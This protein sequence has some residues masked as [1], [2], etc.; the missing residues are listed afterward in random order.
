MNP[1]PPLTPPYRKASTPQ[2]AD[3]ALAHLPGR[4]CRLRRP[5]QL[6]AAA[7][8][9]DAMRAELESAAASLPSNLA[10]P[11]GCS[12]VL[13]VAVE[14]TN[15]AMAAWRSRLGTGLAPSWLN[16]PWLLVEC[17]MYVRIQAAIQAQP[18]LAGEAV[19]PPL[20][21]RQASYGQCGGL[22]KRRRLQVGDG[23]KREGGQRQLRAGVRV[24]GAAAA[25]R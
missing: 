21:R 5:P 8:E 7:R 23:R 18:M 24:W 20:L 2:P 15:D 17:Y 10:A 25:C 22:G 13:S 14:A 16:L 12:G 19:R 3:L 6:R 1:P 11:A 9:I 4:G